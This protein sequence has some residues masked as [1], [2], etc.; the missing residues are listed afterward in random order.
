MLKDAGEIDSTF[1]QLVVAAGSI[2]DFGAIIALSLL[3][4]GEGSTGSTAS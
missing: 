1:G 4:S 2:A 3:F